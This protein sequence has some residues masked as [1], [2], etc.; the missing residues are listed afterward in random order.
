MRTCLTACGLLAALMSWHSQAGQGPVLKI[1]FPSVETVVSGPTAIEI[2]LEPDVPITAIR[3]TVDGIAVC[4]LTRRPFR[5]SWNAGTD[6]KSFHIR[7]V[8]DLPGAE[9]LVA[10][11]R[12]RPLRHVERTGVEA[13]AVSVIVRDGGQFVRGLTKADFEVFE[14]GVPQTI[15]SFASDE[16]PLD[17]IMAVDVSGS[18]ES[19][20]DGVKTAVKQF[21]TK[22]RRGDAATLVG[23]NDTFFVAAERETDPEIR[24][25]AVDL[26]GAWGGTAIYDATVRA[27]DMVTQEHSRKGVVIFSDGADQDSLTTREAA[28]A[29]VQSSEA[30]LYTI[31]FGAGLTVA[32]LRNNLREYAELTGGRPFFPA[33]AR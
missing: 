24:A 3:V 13:V 25:A 20:L 15:S 19:A 17:L 16:A 14:D 1:T 10:N 8:A 2:S 7:V 6:L 12:T 27:L 11:V 21:F 29:R 22:L 32:S 5:C 30:M 31:G 23:F 9:P 26:L 33:D 28:M 4:T 18:M